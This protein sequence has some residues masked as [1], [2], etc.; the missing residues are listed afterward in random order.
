[1]EGIP[2][3][4]DVGGSPGHPVMVS[5]KKADQIKIICLIKL[6]NI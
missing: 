4:I 1:V 6:N 3:V 2:E 5:V